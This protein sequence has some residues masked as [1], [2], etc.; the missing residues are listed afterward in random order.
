MINALPA[1]DKS[2]PTRVQAWAYLQVALEVLH[3]RFHRTL[4]P[5]ENEQ[6]PV[7]TAAAIKKVNTIGLL[8]M[9]CHCH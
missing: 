5:L 1:S 6:P 4:L 8:R 3:L 9:I 7:L 2:I